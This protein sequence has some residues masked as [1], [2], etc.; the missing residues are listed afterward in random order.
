MKRLMIQGLV[1]GASAALGAVVGWCAP[2]E[3]PPLPVGA[4]APS[5]ALLGS[6][7]KAH[8]LTSH[9]GKEAVVLA[10]FPKAFTG[11]WT[12]EV[13]SLRDELSRL[14]KYD[15]AVYAVS[16]DP[17][18]V[19]KDFARENKV[20]YVLLSDASGKTAR[21]YGVLMPNGMA[22][23]VTFVIDRS[24]VIRHVD[25]KVNVRTHGQDLEA[26]LARVAGSRTGHGWGRSAL[27]ARASRPHVVAIRPVC[28]RER[29]GAGDQRAG[30]PRS[31]VPNWDALD[32]LLTAARI[33]AGE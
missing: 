7:G 30:R 8:G 26:V 18:P 23:R 13:C 29:R 25:D 6:D 10:F 1:L 5:F 20:N 31:Q 33:D 16:T 28:A 3:A 19:V 11:G 14:K 17:L 4:K 2:A 22:S 32:R 24:G 9:Q 27:G 15:V 21:A 12:L